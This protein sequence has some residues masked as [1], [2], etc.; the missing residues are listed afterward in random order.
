MRFN[1][2]NWEQ[3]GAAGFS[4]GWAYYTNLAIDSGGRPY[5]AYMAL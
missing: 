4:P 2:A 3:V 1:G 5:I